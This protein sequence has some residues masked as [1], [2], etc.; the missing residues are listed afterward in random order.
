MDRKRNGTIIQT[1]DVLDFSVIHLSVYERLQRKYVKTLINVDKSLEPID[2]STQFLKELVVNRKSRR[3]DDHIRDPNT[4]EYLKNHTKYYLN[5]T[6]AIMPFLGSDMGAGHSV[7]SNRY[8]Y[9]HTCFWSVYSYFP[10]VVISVK[11][12]VDYDYIK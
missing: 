8:K 10:H 5:K 11:T 4:H 12:Q 3:N 7:L 1:L 6:V 9:L 2:K